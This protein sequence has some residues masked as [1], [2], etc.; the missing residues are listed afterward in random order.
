MRVKAA[1]HQY[2]VYYF[3]ARPDEDVEL[4]FEDTDSVAFGP[5]VAG[6]NHVFFV[7]NKDHLVLPIG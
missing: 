5:T 7:H 3:R 1:S 4:L 2:D 6:E